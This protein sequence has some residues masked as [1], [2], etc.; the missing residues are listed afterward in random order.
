MSALFG[1]GGVTGEGV[2]TG[3]GRVT[4]LFGEAAVAVVLA[5]TDDLAV[6]A[7]EAVMVGELVGISLAIGLGEAVA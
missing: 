1:E 3:D 4:G 7:V 6:G 5:D 2:V